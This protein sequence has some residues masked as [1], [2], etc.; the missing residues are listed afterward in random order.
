MLP[1]SGASG[2]KLEAKVFGLE[3]VNV[4]NVGASSLQTARVRLSMTRLVYIRQSL[5]Y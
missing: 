5:S 2:T 3:S 4:K 1:A